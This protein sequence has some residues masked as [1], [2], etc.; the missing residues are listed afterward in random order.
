MVEY[1]FSQLQ[2]VVYLPYVSEY[3]VPHD[4]L[5]QRERHDEDAQREVCHGQ[6]RHEP[7]LDILQRKLAEDGDDDEKVADDDDGGEDDDGGADDGHLQDG[8]AAWVTLSKR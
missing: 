8:E 1:F 7:V 4:L 2:L 6:R 5:R 3:P